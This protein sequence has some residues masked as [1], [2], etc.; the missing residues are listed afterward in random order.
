MSVRIPDSGRLTV[1]RKRRIWRIRTRAFPIEPGL[2][3]SNQQNRDLSRWLIPNDEGGSPGG[4]VRCCNCN[5]HY[6]HC[7]RHA[8]PALPLHRW[9]DRGSQARHSGVSARP[10]HPA[11][12]S[13]P[14]T[15]LE[16]RRHRI[17]RNRD[18]KSRL[19]PSLRNSI[20]RRLPFT[21]LRPLRLA[22]TDIQYFAGRAP[23]HVAQLYIGWR[24]NLFLELI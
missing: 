8:A 9:M 12:A 17:N 24:H 6:N 20:H 16:E 23:E 19:Y 10:L 4:E 7:P 13:K 18:D 15:P 21:L 2:H 14:F 11:F 5:S 1:P 3:E 22:S